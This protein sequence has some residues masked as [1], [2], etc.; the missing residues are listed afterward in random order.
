MPYDLSVEEKR[1]ELIRAFSQ[2]FEVYGDRGWKVATFANA[3]LQ[4]NEDSPTYSLYFGQS[5]GDLA[6]RQ[7]HVRRIARVNNLGEVGN[8][9]LEYTVE[10]FT[11]IFFTGHKDTK[12]SV[13]SL[14]NLVFVITRSMTNLELESLSNKQKKFY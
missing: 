9:E 5:Y 7:K 1:D 12:V 6:D 3:V 8:V 10:D 4:G 2:L 13:H 11:E 14:A